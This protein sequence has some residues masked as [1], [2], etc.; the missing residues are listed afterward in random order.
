MGRPIENRGSTVHSLFVLRRLA[1]PCTLASIIST[2][3]EG[4]IS[5]GQ[6][7]IML[8]RRIINF[9]RYFID[10]K[11]RKSPLSELGENWSV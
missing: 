2:G 7:Q 5:V 10:K 6:V 9:Q 4:E 11:M 8:V 1:L 3:L